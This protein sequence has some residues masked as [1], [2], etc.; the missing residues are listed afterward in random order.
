[1]YK[2]IHCIG[3]RQGLFSL[4]CTKVFYVYIK[5][6]YARMTVS[7]GLENMPKNRS[8]TKSQQ[9]NIRNTLA[10]RGGAIAGRLSRHAIG[11]ED[12]KPSEIKA[13]QIILGKIVPDLQS[14][15]FND[16]TPQ[17]GN[18][19]DSIQAM[20]ELRKQILA[21]ATED[22]IQASRQPLAS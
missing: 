15:E 9:D 7:L 22:E 10:R 1:M 19:E 11:E 12:M 2:T 4:F 20:A 18:P 6:I 8:L 16:V 21:D 13:A 17:Y 5:R 14:T 3:T